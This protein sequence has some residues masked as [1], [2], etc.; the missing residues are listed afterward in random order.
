MDSSWSRAPA[1]LWAVGL[2]GLAWN[3]FG[4]ADYLMSKLRGADHSRAMGMTEAQI[5]W[6]DSLPAWMTLVWA[7]GVWS[8]LLGT[9]LLLARNRLAVPAFLVSLGACVISLVHSFLLS[10]GAAVMG[11]MGRMQWGVLA[12]CIAFASCSL[13]MARTG[14]LR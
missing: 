13:A 9:L 4:A 2:L 3:G 10:D 12:G 7:V 11:D 1:H 14:V 6:M 5:A 8:A